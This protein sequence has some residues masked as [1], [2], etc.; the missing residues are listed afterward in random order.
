FLHAIKAL[1]REFGSHSMAYVLVTYLPVPDHIHEM[2][3][4]PTQQA[5][6]LLGQEGIQPDFIICRA[7]YTVDAVRRKKI[8]EFVN[9]APDHVISA[10]DIDTVYQIPLDLEAENMG[11]KILTHLNLTSKK[12]PD[13]S[14]WKK[15]VNAIVNPTKTIT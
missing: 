3:T 4:K 12:Q 11:T 7:K 8:E 2:K 1:E 13:W 9:L 14:S 5:I 6:R 15:L 10:P